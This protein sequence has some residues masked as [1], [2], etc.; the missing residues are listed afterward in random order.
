M[1]KE[2]VLTPE[3]HKKLLQDLEA[4]RKKRKEISSRIQEAKELGDLSE[5]AEYHEAKNDQAFTEG[6]IAEIGALL[7]NARVV[8]KTAKNS[9]IVQLGS[10]VTVS[11][12][13]KKISYHIVGINEAD[14]L[15]GKISNESP[16]GKMFLGKK[17]GDTV[18]VTTPKGQQDF[19]IEEIS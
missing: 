8:K 11:Q 12:N 6:R 19:L 5:N 7:N 9:G 13:G 18:E 14:P 16:L 17:K 3:G 2:T 10:T 4:L 15:N 1:A